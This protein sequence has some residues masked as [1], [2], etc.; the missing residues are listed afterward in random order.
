MKTKEEID[1]ITVDDEEQAVPFSSKC[2][3]F[4]SFDPLIC[5]IVRT[6]VSRSWIAIK[7]PF[8]EAVRAP[9]TAT[10]ELLDVHRDV[11]D[12]EKLLVEDIKEELEVRYT[13]YEGG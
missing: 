11:V 10:E 1:E 2:M 3:Y 5:V 12:G 6:I 13:R 7:N 9:I 8:P 4:M